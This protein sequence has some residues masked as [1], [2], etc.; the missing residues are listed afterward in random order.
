MTRPTIPRRKDLENEYFHPVLKCIL[1]EIIDERNWDYGVE[2]QYESGSGP[3]DLVVTN[4]KTGKVLFPLEVKRTIAAVKGPGRRQARDYSNNLG[5]MRQTQ[6]YCVSNIEVVELFKNTTGRAKTS[7]QLIA[8]DNPRCGTLEITPDGE[9]Y[10][11]LKESLTQVMEICLG[12]KEAKYEVGLPELQE[13]LG[14]ST[15]YDAWHKTLTPACFEYIRGASNRFNALKPHVGK[16]K[17]ARYYLQNPYRLNELGQK[18]DFEHVFKEPSLDYSDKESLSGELLA[19]SYKAGEEGGLGDDIASLVYEILSSSPNEQGIVETD[20]E[21]ADLLSSFS[22]L[23]LDRELS[24]NELALD[25]G[26]GSGRLLSSLQ[27]AF[28]SISPAQLFAIEA[29]DR[30]GE[31][32]S[33]RL[34]LSYANQISPSCKPKVMMQRLESVSP[35]EFSDVALTVMNPPFISGVN[36]KKQKAGFSE[37]IKK[38]TG[39]KPLLAKGQSALELLYLEL[40]CSLVKDNSVI[41]SI[42]PA[43][44]LVRGAKEAVALRNYLL[45][46][47]GLKYIVKYPRRGLFETVVKDTVLL[48]GKKGAVKSSVEII[49]IEKPLADIDITELRRRLSSGQSVDS[50]GVS[51]SR[52]T[53]NELLDRVKQGWRE[54][55]GSGKSST[56]CVEELKLKYNMKEEVTKSRVFRGTLNNKGNS[57]LT[58]LK[59]LIN[60][61]KQAYQ[62]LPSSWVRPAINTVKGMPRKISS[63]TS[64]QQSFLPPS[65]AFE[66]KSNNR[67]QLG[68]L[69][70]KYLTTKQEKSSGSQ[71]KKDKDADTVF[72]DLKS[73]LK[74]T[75]PYNAVFPR[76]SRRMAQV[77]VH[78][79]DN[80]MFSTNTILVGAN[81]EEEATL[82]ASFLLSIFGQ[83]QL[84]LYG[85]MQE[86]ARKLEIGNVSRVKLPD[87]TLLASTTKEK[88]IKLY[89]ECPDRDFYNLS[90]NQ[91][92]EEWGKVIVP[93]EYNQVIE[94]VFN[95]F[96]SL[97]DERRA[98]G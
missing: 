35:R 29:E 85:V 46:T 26:A 87:L 27:S 64:H 24:H 13:I 41:S 76:N 17:N 53:H 7:A 10:R 47:F 18:F 52:I 66:E 94:K 78:V 34:G 39:Q 60:V 73:D 67:F 71:K 88:L 65:D 89:F 30:F 54:F 22:K 90:L 80:V 15:S 4:N 79:S 95:N 28:P 38:L 63:S 57:S 59:K 3:I 55:M 12:E 31:S 74:E 56:N 25:P 42:F 43:Q 75:P 16:W 19:G 68:N 69:I 51:T 97:V 84:E 21:L 36:S 92:D 44:H 37:T 61:S 2:E 62:L 50:I 49:E 9:F 5:A 83:V 82:I 20:P 58:V 72:K 11:K 98:L 45:D 8:I 70:N 93:K 14:S 86:G 40:V 6:F 81:S 91:L 77:S 33:L 96:Q 1:D 23:A 32:L 48:V